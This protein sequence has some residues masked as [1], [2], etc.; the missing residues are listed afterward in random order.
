[1]PWRRADPFEN[2]SDSVDQLK[3]AARGA[4]HSG[5]S[6]LSSKATVSELQQ[7]DDLDEL[8]QQLNDF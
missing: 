7:E 6:S 1:M 5:N 3:G 2:L 8:M 4:S